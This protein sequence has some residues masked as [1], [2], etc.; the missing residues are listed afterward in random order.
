M[1]SGTCNG[2]AVQQLK[3]IKI[4][5]PQK[6]VCCALLIWKLAPYIERLLRLPEN[7][8]DAL[9]GTELLIH[10]CGIAFISKRKLIFQINK[11]VID[12][13]C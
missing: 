13:R 9:G 10:L 1:L 5:I 11:F 12:R 7:F 2:H 3:E 6:L 4:Q 8:I